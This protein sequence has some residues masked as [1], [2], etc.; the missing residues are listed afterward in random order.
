MKY[1]IVNTFTLFS[2]LIS[3]FATF[4]LIRGDFYTSLSLILISFLLDMLDGFIA[5]RLDAC[6]KFGRVFDSIS[7]VFIFIVFPIIFIYLYFGVDN[8]LQEIILFIFLCSGIYRLIRFTRLGLLVQEENIYYQGMPVFFSHPILLTL[9]LF[10]NIWPDISSGLWPSMI[11]IYS[12][13][14]V[15][16]IRFRKPKSLWSI[17]SISCFILI[18]CIY[19]LFI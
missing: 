18:V 9:I 7:D 12:G 19:L 13:F 6:S 15:S 17:L 5:R 11:M 1:L 14:M 2:I 4:L 3:F 8:I 16:M 10:R